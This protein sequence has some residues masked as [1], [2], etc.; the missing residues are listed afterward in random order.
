LGEKNVS[1]S[2]YGYYEDQD[3]LIDLAY[4]NPAH[5]DLLLDIDLEDETDSA[6]AMSEQ[7]N[8]LHFDYGHD[9]LSDFFGTKEAEVAIASHH[10][11]NNNEEGTLLID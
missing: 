5:Q 2:S 1:S 11:G 8:V 10:H 4:E 6:T 7:Q 9:I 3:T